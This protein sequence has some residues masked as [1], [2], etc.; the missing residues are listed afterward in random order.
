MKTVLA[1]WP[2]KER[3]FTKED[4]APMGRARKVNLFSAGVER[5]EKALR[6]FPRRMW[7]YTQS[8]ENWTIIQIL[9]HLADQEANLYMRLR[10]AAAEPG[11][12]L[13]AYDQN[14]WD[15]GLLYQKADPEQARDILLLLRKANADLVKRL[16]P[17]AWNKQVVHPEY[18]KRPFSYFVGMNIWHLDHHLAQMGRRYTEWKNTGR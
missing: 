1:G 9:W 8:P 16:G 12:P 6:K 17:S 2:L 11:H 15:K 4:V 7:S 18:G 10:I 5:V 13:T 14:K 3:Y